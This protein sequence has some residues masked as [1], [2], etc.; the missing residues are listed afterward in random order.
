MIYGCSSCEPEQKIS[1]N[2]CIILLKFYRLL[3]YLK[4][5][6]KNVQAH[7]QN[8][9]FGYRSAGNKLGGD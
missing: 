3:T 7:Y 1:L 4:F 6:L 9:R 8:V 2:S 5:N